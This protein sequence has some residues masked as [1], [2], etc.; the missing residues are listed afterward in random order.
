PESLIER[1]PFPGPGLSVRALC[2]DG[3]LPDIAE[4]AC[5][6]IAEIANRFGFESFVLPV[7]SVG[8]QGDFRTY[9]CPAV[10]VGEGDWRALEQASTAITNSVRAVN[11]VVRL[12][13]P[14][15]LPSLAP[16]ACYL[17]RARLDLLREADAIAMSTL[18]KC[19]L[20][21]EV[22]QMPTVLVPLTDDG[23]RECIVLRPLSSRDVMTARFAELPGEAVGEMARLI[24]ALPGIA[25]VFYDVTHK[26]PAT[27]EWE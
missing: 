10:L 26:P 5:L 17:T 9:A 27:M 8:V 1:H 12:L 23:E 15:K 4:G 14:A 13:A 21:A 25:A 16:K 6:Q 24:M 18:H 2:S 3:S 7:R 19:G 11:R 20:M 22:F